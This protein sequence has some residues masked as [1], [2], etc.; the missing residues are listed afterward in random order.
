M[1]LETY[2]PGRVAF[3]NRDDSFRALRLC[4]K[5]SPTG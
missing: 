4:A 1:L 3:Y 5:S 2:S